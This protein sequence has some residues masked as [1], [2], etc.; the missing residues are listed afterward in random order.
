MFSDG[1]WSRKRVFDLCAQAREIPLPTSEEMQNIYESIK[2]PEFTEEKLGQGRMGGPGPLPKG[3]SFS[4]TQPFC[5]GQGAIM[6]CG[7]LRWPH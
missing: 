4:G 6:G 7:C 5:W 3:D 2:C 1:S